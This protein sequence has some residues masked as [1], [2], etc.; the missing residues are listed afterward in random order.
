MSCPILSHV[1][2]CPQVVPHPALSR[3]LPCPQV[4]P[5]PAIRPCPALASDC[6][7]SCPQTLPRPALRPCRALPSN[8]PCHDLPSVVPCTALRPCPDR[9]STV[10]CPT[11]RQAVP[12]PSFRP[13]HALLCLPSGRALFC[14]QFLPC[15]AAA[16][17]PFLHRGARTIVR[18]RGRGVSMELGAPDPQRTKVAPQR[19]W[20][21]NDIVQFKP[22]PNR[23]F[24]TW[25]RPRLQKWTGKGHGCSW[26][27][28]RSQ[29]RSIPNPPK[30]FMSGDGLLR[31]KLSYTWLKTC[32]CDN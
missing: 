8:R 18:L 26:S 19:T 31:N 28:C 5:H 2:P 27:C 24:P 30:N 25:F 29:V 3:A 21:P 1:L 11:L 12:C 22:K 7:L 32:I 16:L 10:P 6:A 4:V 14:P 17:C 20:F 13:C 15:P 9:P 23:R